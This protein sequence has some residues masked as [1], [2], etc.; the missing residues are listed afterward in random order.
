M[1][2]SQRIGFCKNDIGDISTAGRPQP[3]YADQR[4]EAHKLIQQA[5]T[6]NLGDTKTTITH[7]SST[8]H[9]RL[10]EAQRQSAGITQGMVR[11]A[12]GLDDVRDIMA[13]LQRGM[14]GL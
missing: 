5:I 1:P 12:M 3:A 6:A 7:P 9:G 13:D 10:S 4:A 8:S 14:A 11:L 2:R